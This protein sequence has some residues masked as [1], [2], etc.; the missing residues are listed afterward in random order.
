[1]PRKEAAMDEF[2][3]EV[4]RLGQWP[5]EDQAHFVAMLRRVAADARVRRADRAQIGRRA[6]ALIRL[7]NLSEKAG[8]ARESLGDQNS[9]PS[10]RAAARRQPARR[11]KVQ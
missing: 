4:A 8:E 9:P 10:P 2:A 3:E 11:K 5:R 6:E 7:L 1:M